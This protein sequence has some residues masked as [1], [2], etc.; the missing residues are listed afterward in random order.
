MVATTERK[1]PKQETISR[2]VDLVGN[3][4]KQTIEPR[5]EEREDEEG[6]LD[7]QSDVMENPEGLSFS[8]SHR[9]TLISALSSGSAESSYDSSEADNRSHVSSQASS[10]VDAIRSVRDILDHGTPELAKDMKQAASRHGLTPRSSRAPDDGR[11][12]L[13][14]NERA[15]VKARKISF[16]VPISF[17]RSMRSSRPSSRK[18][19]EEGLSHLSY[20]SSDSGTSYSREE[21]P[22]PVQFDDGESDPNQSQQGDEYEEEDEVF[23]ESSGQEEKEQDEALESN[24]SQEEEAVEER[25]D[26]RASQD[27]H[28]STP[29]AFTRSVSTQGQESASDY[30]MGPR[31][32]SFTGD[33]K[34]TIN[35]QPLMQ[36]SPVLGSVVGA[37]QSDAMKVVSPASRESEITRARSPVSTTFP[38]RQLSETFSTGLEELG[39]FVQRQVSA[40]AGSLE[41]HD[42]TAVSKTNS[43]VTETFC[44]RSVVSPPLEE[45]SDRVVSNGVSLVDGRDD[46]E[47]GRCGT[48]SPE[49]SAVNKL[50]EVR[51]MIG[52]HPELVGVLNSHLSRSE[53]P[54]MMSTNSSEG[55]MGSIRKHLSRLRKRELLDR[56]TTPVLSST[57][58]AGLG[59]KLSRQ[60][61]NT[62]NEVSSEVAPVSKHAKSST[63]VKS[64]LATVGTLEPEEEEFTP[65]PDV[66][67]SPIVESILSD[68]SKQIPADFGLET[69]QNHMPKQSSLRDTRYSKSLSRDTSEK[70]QSPEFEMVLNNE[71]VEEIHVERDVNFTSED[72]AGELDDVD[73]VSPVFIDNK[74]KKRYTL[75]CN[76][77]A[78]GY[79][80]EAETSSLVSS[81]K[82]SEDESSNVVC[83]QAY[84]DCEIVSDGVNGNIRVAERAGV[85]SLAPHQTETFVAN[86]TKRKVKSPFMKKLVRFVG[87]GKHTKKSDATTAGNTATVTPNDT[88]TYHLE[89]AV[90]RKTLPS[91]AAEVEPTP[92][93]SKSDIN[94][95]TSLK[96]MKQCSL[97]G[98]LDSWDPQLQEAG[99]IV[100]NPSK[101]LEQNLSPPGRLALG[102]S[103]SQ[104]EALFPSTAEEGEPISPAKNLLQTLN[105]FFGNQETKGANGNGEKVVSFARSETRDETVVSAQLEDVHNMMSLQRP[106]G[107]PGGTVRDPARLKF[108]AGKAGPLQVAIPT[109]VPGSGSDHSF[110]SSTKGTSRDRPKSA[111]SGRRPRS[112][113]GERPHRKTPIKPIAVGE[114][115]WIRSKNGGHST[116]ASRYTYEASQ[117]DQNSLDAGTP[118]PVISPQVASTTK[119]IRSRSRSSHR[120]SRGSKSV[121]SKHS[122]RKSGKTVKHGL[123][124]MAGE[125]HA[126]VRF[127]AKWPTLEQITG[128]N[129]DASIRNQLRSA[130][131]DVTCTW[132]C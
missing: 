129:G 52:G 66:P 14:P 85:I 51:Q 122:R 63:I 73:Y 41:E 109:L 29:F 24:E 33:M 123:A 84:S 132:L 127:V 2:S 88:T 128:M 16:P 97:S 81:S 115:T 6:E 92:E 3:S 113:S 28:T 49:I 120:T 79:E 20:V 117:L 10:V 19:S 105:P 71:G 48:A 74:D 93:E 90:E 56:N 107:S 7:E 87:R 37:P 91:E 47:I 8:L 38:A 68:R 13:A 53:S 126:D 42:A 119:M 21:G 57:H 59:E 43:L 75:S 39:S 26:A 58:T 78:D 55:A 50:R 82:L 111:R 11:P 30:S 69:K 31:R 32:F 46:A 110:Q 86:T 124:G 80:V 61:D 96:N 23:S 67:L 4:T 1:L 25:E 99:I 89:G 121:S 44:P 45:C 77:V 76:Q 116:P 108:L 102:E 106:V 62:E 17:S 9:N 83:D 27:M 5:L 54:M 35:Q 114:H 94:A 18:S 100:L 64:I 131:N 104:P 72:T 12:P 40:H 130:V 101:T 22:S 125:T 98:S 36:R 70:C 15:S 118:G 103:S 34:T 112:Q 65:S 95:V 60:A